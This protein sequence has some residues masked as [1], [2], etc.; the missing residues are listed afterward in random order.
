MPSVLEQSSQGVGGQF[1]HPGPAFSQVVLA[2]EIYRATPK[3]QSA[4]LEAMEERQV[5]VDGHTHVLPEPFFVIATQNPLSQAGTFP[6]PESQLD[7]FLMR[8]QLGYPSLDAEKTMLMGQKGRASASGLV[9]VVDQAGLQAMQAQVLDVKVS[10]SLLDC[11][12]LVNFSRY[13]AGLAYGLS[14]RGSLAWLTAARVGL[15]GRLM[16][17][18][19]MCSSLRP[20]CSIIG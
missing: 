12:R 1:S 18:Q 15:L 19:K 11:V 13:E 10:Q 6:L 14:P 17:C 8:I 3:A 2:D 9:Q 4:L 7:R 16:Y 20:V 5:S